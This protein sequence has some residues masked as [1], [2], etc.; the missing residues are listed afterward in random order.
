MAFRDY[1]QSRKTDWWRRHIIISSLCYLLLFLPVDSA[2]SAPI[3]EVTVLIYHHFGVDKYP[4]TNVSVE[5]FRAQMAYLAAN[6]YRILPLAE[7]VDSLKNHQ[8]LPD[9]AVVITIDDGYESVY[10]NGWPILKSYGFP[11]TVFI[12]AKSIEKKFA[13]YLD[14]S[15]IREMQADGVDFQSH[16]YSHNRM[17]DR[18]EGLDD[19]SYRRWIRDDLVTN[20]KIIEERLGFKPRYFAIPYGEYNRQIIEEAGKLGFEAVL[21]QDPGSISR[22]TD[23]YLIPR[24]PIL[25]QEWSSLAHFIEILD[26]VDLPIT[27]LSPGYGY[28]AEEPAFFGA[29]ILHPEFYADSSLMVY[30]SEFGWLD[31]K[32]AGDL[33]RAPGGG[34]LT[35]KLNRVMVK[36]KERGSGRTAVRSWLL[37][38]EDQPKRPVM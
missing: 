27:D 19:S 34:K 22:A 9:K 17:A 20:S 5:K 6:H 28:V 25:G 15:T 24:E 26:R 29:R 8:P 21:T 3:P 14:W 4:T 23:P 38:R 7:L 16:G 36:G 33:L 30:V 2:W 11:F 12:N 37:I 18:P 10:R 31:S 13:N 35:R 32:L 1:G